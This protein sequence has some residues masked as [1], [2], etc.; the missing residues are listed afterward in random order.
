MGEPSQLH[1][2]LFILLFK[3]FG[4]LTD[5]GQRA[6]CDYFANPPL[7]GSRN[8]AP[9]ESYTLLDDSLQSGF[10]WLPL[11]FIW[12]ARVTNPRAPTGVEG[13]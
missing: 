10:W 3:L 13:T 1:D 7:R 4:G 8:N 12:T 11:E 6:E 5:D 2:T 9:N